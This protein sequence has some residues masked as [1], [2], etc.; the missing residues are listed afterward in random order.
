MG[1]SDEGG[2]Q[3]TDDKATARPIMFLSRPWGY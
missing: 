2:T 3:E 1:D